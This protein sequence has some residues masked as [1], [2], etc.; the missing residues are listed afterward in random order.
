MSLLHFYLRRTSDYISLKYVIAIYIAILFLG[1]VRV[2]KSESNYLTT[3][4]KCDSS[5]SVSSDEDIRQY[6]NFFM[7]MS[8]IQGFVSIRHKEEGK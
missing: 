3:D 7:F 6:E 2:P 8:T 1:N 5:I 4:G